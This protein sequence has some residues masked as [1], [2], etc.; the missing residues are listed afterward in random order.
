MQYEK[1]Q[2]V[3]YESKTTP[4]EPGNLTGHKETISEAPPKEIKFVWTEPVKGEPTSPDIQYVLNEI[5]RGQTE[6][7]QRVS[8]NIT[9]STASSEQI[10]QWERQIKISDLVAGLTRTTQSTEPIGFAGGQVFTLKEY[11]EAQLAGLQGGRTTAEKIGEAIRNEAAGV[12]SFPGVA[13]ATLLAPTKEQARPALTTNVFGKEQPIIGTAEPSVTT[14]QKVL[15][16]AGLAVMGAGVLAGAGSHLA[17]IVSSA[18]ATGLGGY[19]VVKSLPGAMRGDI[20]SIVDLAASGA[21][22][23]LGTYGLIKTLSPPTKVE[24]IATVDKTDIYFKNENVK[25][26]DT[27]AL[28]SG[29]KLKI[30]DPETGKPVTVGE[31]KGAGEVTKVGESTAT[32]KNLYTVDM[33]VKVKIYP[34]YAN[35]FK[36]SPEVIEKAGYVGTTPAD[37]TF[38]HGNVVFNIEKGMKPTFEVSSISDLKSQLQSTF[39]FDLSHAT[40]EMITKYSLEVSP[41]KESVGVSWKTGEMKAKAGEGYFLKDFLGRNVGVKSIKTYGGISMSTTGESASIGE[42]QVMSGATRVLTSPET[43][44]AG[45]LTTE[46]TGA[47]LAEA[48]KPSV[49][50]TIKP[51]TSSILTGGTSL[52]AGSVGALG[53]QSPAAQLIENVNV[54]NIVS[55]SAGFS[56]NVLTTYPKEESRVIKIKPAVSEYQLQALLQQELTKKEQERQAQTT[57]QTLEYKPKKEESYLSQVMEKLDLRPRTNTGQILGLSSRQINEQAQAQLQAAASLQLQKIREKQKVVTPV[58]P[59]G[60][61][62]I[63]PPQVPVTVPVIN[64]PR[65]MGGRTRGSKK[66]YWGYFE[67]KWPVV[68]TPKE[69]RKVF[70][71]L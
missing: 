52:G 54:P 10:K 19:G 15:A 35:R 67:R 23:G 43:F 59:T 57:T 47:S 11:R 27:G 5:E 70:K 56:S 40:S 62:N 4:I 37:I 13:I 22:A 3:V 8:P 36:I 48:I 41:P 17:S 46:V 39:A 38:E 44:G 16:G 33:P 14:E 60:S 28:K 25:I 21:V 55:Q 63:W 51:T 65:I 58:V 50:V 34:E 64:L 53:T 32:G 42:S 30:V 31:W 66:G 45:G 18:G 2:W 6:A 9:T 12:I 71:K 69:L 29:G 20:Q 1:G 68:S 61:F 24:S 49:S 7:M 26:G